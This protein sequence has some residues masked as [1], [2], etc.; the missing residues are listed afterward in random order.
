MERRKVSKVDSVLPATTTGPLSACHRMPK[1]SQPRFAMALHRSHCSFCKPFALQRGPG[2]GGDG[3]SR[4]MTDKGADLGVRATPA[5]SRA[6]GVCGHARR[7]Y[8]KGLTASLKVEL[9][10]T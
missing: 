4:S 5:L 10:L 6:G 8:D 7:L 1:P 3:A 9:N 2:R